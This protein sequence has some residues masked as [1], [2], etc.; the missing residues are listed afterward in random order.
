[1]QKI[2]CLLL[3][4]LLIANVCQAQF[5][6]N[7]G[8]NGAPYVFAPAASTGLDRVFVFN[9]MEN[10]RL[11]YT[12]ANPAA[13][14]W[15]RYG[16]NSSVAVEIASSDIETTAGTTI[17][18]NIQPGNGYYVDLGNTSRRYAWVMEYLPV[19][20]GEIEPCSNCNVCQT[21]ELSAPV[22]N[23]EDLVYYSTSGNKLLLKRQ[24]RLSW[25]TLEWDNTDKVYKTV[26]KTVTSQ[27]S[28]A[29]SIDAPLTDTYF[30][31]GD[32]LAFFFGETKRS[33]SLYKA[34][35]VQ[36]NPDWTIEERTADNELDKVSTTGDLSGSAPLKVHF[37]SHPSDAVQSYVWEVY[38]TAD[39]SANVARH[40]TEENLEQEFD[41]AGSFLVAVTASSTNGTCSQ[42]KTFTASVS[43][44]YIECPNF[45]TPRS[46]PGENDEF[47][48]A[49]KSIL[50]FKGVIMNRWGNVLFEWNDPSKGWNGTYKGKAVSPGVYFYLIEAK[51]SDGL[52]YKKKGDINLLE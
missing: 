40:T 8:A 2:R 19:D 7:G 13:C 17:L 35:A 49:Y 21:L 1:M 33:Q 24:Y 3:A 36:I 43:D 6:A 45:F 9:G 18:T 23:A 38:E 47:K 16:Q 41:R 30:T 32:Q 26:E 11:T 27:Y 20:Y 28:P 10:A 25:N 5:S 37:E 4:G 31:I 12:T 29:W 34:V 15:Y 39:S 51:G 50:S 14:K 46:S 22:N 52:E 44:S 42:R 48:V